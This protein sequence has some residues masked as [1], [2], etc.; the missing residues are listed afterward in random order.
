LCS[1]Y[2]QIE[3]EEKDKIKTAF[4]TED[5]HYEFNRMPFGLANAPATFQR[6]LDIVLRPAKMKFAMVYLDD[7]SLF[8]KTIRDHLN[9]LRS[10]FDLLRKAG[11]KIKPSKCI[12]L[13][14]EVEY[15][16]HIFT[17]EGY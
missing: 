12:F 16:G 8:S 6:F 7:V 15:L 1:G 2:W 13:Q 14:I 9:Y 3:I 17:K 5:G 10:V 11:L 4:T